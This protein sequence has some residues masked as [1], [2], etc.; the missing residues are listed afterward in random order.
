MAGREIVDVHSHL[1][2]RSYIDRLKQRST[3]PRIVG[4]QEAE[5]FVIFPDEERSEGGRL[6]GRDYWD[7]D[8]KLA[9]MDEFGIDSTVLSLGNPWMDPF[10]HAES[11]VLA[12]ALN[13]EFSHLADESGGRIFGLGVFPSGDVDDALAVA[14]EVA[15]YPT[16]VG[17][18]TGPRLCGRVFDNGALEPIWE[19]L[20]ERSVPLFVHPHY[21]AA[22]DDLSGTDHALPVGLAFPFETTIAIARLVF[23]GV[24][25]RHP[26]LEVVAAHGGGTIPFVAGRLDAAWA[27]DPSTHAKLPEP[28]SRSLGRLYVD[29]VVY[30][31]RAMRAAADLVGTNRLTFGTDHPFSVADPDANLRAINTAFSGDDRENVLARSAKNLFRLPAVREARSYGKT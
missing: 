4:E 21:G 30:H 7:L 28:P 29:C 17:M 13:E 19:F 18:I 22:M 20:A 24:L 27:S 23:A 31:E 12:R 11:V 2:P 10:D 8:A 26:G 6:M 3:I 14:E 5:R 9:F 1:Y 16:L 15:A 25:R